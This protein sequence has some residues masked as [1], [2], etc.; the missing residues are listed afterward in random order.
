MCWLC[1]GVRLSLAPD[2]VWPLPRG[3][4]LSLS[5]CR[6]PAAKKRKLVPNGSQVKRK[7]SSSSDDSSS[8]EE[9]PP[10]KKPGEVC[11]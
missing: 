5:T 3:P 11:E 4:Q 6:S 1:R 8:E 9:T 10:A 7:P 2:A